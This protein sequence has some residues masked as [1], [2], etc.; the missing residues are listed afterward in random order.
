[1]ELFDSNFQIPTSNFQSG[2][3]LKVTLSYNILRRIVDRALHEDIGPGDITTLSVI[4]PDLTGRG[5][6][7]TKEKGVIAGLPVAAAVFQRLD[8]EILF[9]PQVGEGTY[10]SAAQIVA[11]VEGRLQSILSGERLALNFLQRLSGIATYTA[12]LK[13]IIK[14]FPVN[15][16]DTRKTI[17]GL[18]VL[19][20]YAVRVGGGYNHRFGLFDGILIKNNHLKIAGGVTRAVQKARKNISPMIKIEVEVEDLAGVE[21]ALA[22][23]VDIIMLDNMAPDVMRQ[24]V[25]IIDGRA[26]TEASGKVNEANILEVAKSGVDFISVGAITHSARALDISLSA[27]PAGRQV[28]GKK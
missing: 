6:I 18:R 1:M 12:T 27:V 10:A 4:D 17:P 5:Y 28:E 20:K 21:E 8:Q 22:A 16:I 26:R 14:D 11:V 2:V 13:E 9:T 3:S 19:E 7:R 25:K 15:I 23:G 24:A